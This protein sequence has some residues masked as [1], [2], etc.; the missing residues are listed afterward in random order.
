MTPFSV[1]YKWE[2]IFARTLMEDTFYY[3]L[4][5]CQFGTFDFQQIDSLMPMWKV[6]AS[7]ELHWRTLFVW[8][9]WPL[10]M[11][12]A[13]CKYFMDAHKLISKQILHWFVFA[14]QNYFLLSFN[15]LSYENITF[16]LL[17][18]KNAFNIYITKGIF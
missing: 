3:L 5:P 16:D 13:F 7:N 8:S 10:K 18:N 15:I 17:E 12:F 2:L 4:N 11:Y 9:L 1:E 6:L 14:F